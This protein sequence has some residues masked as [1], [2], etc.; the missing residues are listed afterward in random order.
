MIIIKEEQQNTSWNLTLAMDN[1]FHCACGKKLKF[2]KVYEF[3]KCFHSYI[4]ACKNKK[5]NKTW[6][7]T[8]TRTDIYEM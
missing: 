3:D 1:K 8:C 4:A 6:R 2:K 5:C 7:V